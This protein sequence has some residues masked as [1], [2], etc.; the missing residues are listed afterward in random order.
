MTR[1]RA[2]QTPDQYTM[3]SAQLKIIKVLVAELSAAQGHALIDAVDAAELEDD[4]DEDGEWE[5]DPT[6]FLDLGAG[7]TKAQLMSLGAD[8]GEMASRG[9][10][11][12]TQAYLVD[13]FRQAAQ[14]PGFA[15]VFNHLTQDEQERLKTM[16]GA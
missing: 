14:K 3:V 5:D 7:M 10:D 4:D 12:E 2:R 8:D 16:S 6:D 11:D 9:R 15:G 1:A 13:F